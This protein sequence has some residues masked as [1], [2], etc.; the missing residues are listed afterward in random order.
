MDKRSITRPYGNGLDKV[1]MKKIGIIDLG[2]NT[3]NLLLTEVEGNNYTILHK[4]KIAVK[5]GEGGITKGYIAP[6]AYQRGLDALTKYKE[7]LLEHQV[8][9][10]YAVATSA[11]RSADNG[12]QFVKDVQE[13]IGISINVIDGNKEAEL[14]YHGVKQAIDLE[15][16]P[17][18]IIDIGGGSTEF[19]IANSHETFWKKS[20]QLGAA[21]LLE[22]FTPKDPISLEDVNA[23]EQHLEDSLGDMIEMA[24]TY[25]IDCLIGSSGS[26]DT[27][28][29]MI[30][31]KKGN[32]AAWKE[33]KHFDFDMHDYNEIQRLIYGSTLE[34]RLEMDGLIPMRADMIVISIV[35]INFILNKLTIH[36]LRLSSYALKEGLI[37][38][39]LSKPHQWQKSSL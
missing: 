10:F 32:C 38:T 30:S 1:R 2:T 12:T 15:E 29:E 6:N 28:A 13:Q 22:K 19:I 35:I 36:D 39:L 25:E 11:I 21:R 27:L 9:N 31:C 7:T 24:E 33:E 20:Y 18:L 16:Q 37:N 4:N 5:L 3:F 17:K 14:I 34:E 26:F 8:D 23:I